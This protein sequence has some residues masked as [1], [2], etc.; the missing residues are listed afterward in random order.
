MSLH[1]SATTG[2]IGSTPANLALTIRDDGKIST[3][4]GYHVST[5]RN[6]MI[7]SVA[8]NSND[9]GLWFDTDAAVINGVASKTSTYFGGD[10]NTVSF[11]GG[12]LAR[13]SVNLNTGAQF[14][15]WQRTGYDRQWD[16]F[17][18]ISVLNDTTNG[19]CGEFRIHGL[20]GVS[21]GDF[22]VVTRSD[23]GYVSG[24]DARRKINVQPISG[25][26]N[27]VVRL[28]GKTFNIINR[29]GSIDPYLSGKKMGWIAQE[30]KDIIPELVTFDKDADTP[31][32]NGWASAYAIDYAGSA[33]LLGEAI[34]ELKGQLDTAL[35]RI[36][37]L[38]AKLA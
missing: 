26:L 29:E 9:F 37:D 33:P 27:K 12:G 24:S 11:I 23:G 7:L 28:S 14:N 34:K 38:E 8:S 31:N 30:A 35:K 3:L 4:A 5:D 10:S 25:A 1:F 21:G 17:P 16:N 20:P 2:Q 32:D 19:P 13:W 36:A 22:S 15:W 6:Q 18:S